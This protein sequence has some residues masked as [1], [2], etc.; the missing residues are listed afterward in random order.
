MMEQRRLV[1]QGSHKS[2]QGFEEVAH[3]LGFDVNGS[4]F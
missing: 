2:W 1:Y 3:F 4:P